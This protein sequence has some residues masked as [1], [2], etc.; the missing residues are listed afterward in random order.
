MRTVAIVFGTGL[1][2]FQPKDD[3]RFAIPLRHGLATDVSLP[4]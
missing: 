3:N 4:E 1:A 2:P